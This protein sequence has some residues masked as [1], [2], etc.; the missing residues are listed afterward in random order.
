[1]NRRNG[2]EEQIELEQ[3]KGGKNNEYKKISV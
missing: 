2:R 1:M 3:L